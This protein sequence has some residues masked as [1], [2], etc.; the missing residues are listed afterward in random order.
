M[1]NLITPT[2]PR[3]FAARIKADP[4]LFAGLILGVASAAADVAVTVRNRRRSQREAQALMESYRVVPWSLK[5]HI[6]R[7]GHEAPHNEG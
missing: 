2:A 1:A 6:E 3:S 5:T 4:L 7:Y